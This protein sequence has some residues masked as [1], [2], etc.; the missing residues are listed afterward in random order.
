MP[1]AS[2]TSSRSRATWSRA[3]V[4]VSPQV[5]PGVKVGAGAVVKPKQIVGR[6][7]PAAEKEA[8]K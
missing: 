4:L 6:N 8:L 2:P 3:L 5:G 1:G 7:V